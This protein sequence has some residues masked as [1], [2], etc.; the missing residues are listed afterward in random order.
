MVAT[1]RCATMHRIDAKTGSRSIIDTVHNAYKP[2]C[3]DIIPAAH[4]K[5]MHEFPG[6]QSSSRLKRK[7]HGNDRLEAFNRHV[8][9]GRNC[10]S[11]V[12]TCAGA[13]IE[14]KY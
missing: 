8:G 14:L 4:L 7:S 12:C 5:F 3:V 2:H 9:S 6:R 11:A 13:A 10:N 1:S